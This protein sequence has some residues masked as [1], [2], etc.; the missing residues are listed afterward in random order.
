MSGPMKKP[1]PLPG[2]NFVVTSSPPHHSHTHHLH[3]DPP[4][5]TEHQIR[6][7]DSMGNM[8]KPTDKFHT[9]FYGQTTLDMFKK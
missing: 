4:V 2:C 6:P 8:M 7:L 9:P 3:N 1:E 5:A